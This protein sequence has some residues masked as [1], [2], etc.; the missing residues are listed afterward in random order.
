MPRR[1]RQALDGALS[2][3]ASLEAAGDSAHATGDIVAAAVQELVDHGIEWELEVG[4]FTLNAGGWQFQIP[5][6]I[7]PVRLRM[8]LPKSEGSKT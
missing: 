5:K 4:P 7:L 8:K 1:L 2:A 3:E 6:H